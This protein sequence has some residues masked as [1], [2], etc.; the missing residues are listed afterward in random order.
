MT[1]FVIKHAKLQYLSLGGV[2]TQLFQ[3]KQNESS[4]KGNAGLDLHT[5]ER[6]EI[7]AGI[8]KC[9]NRYYFPN[10]WLHYMY[11]SQ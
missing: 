11:I 9:N 5:K 7:T 8:F 1:P 4:T 6:M 10:N 3:P 2:R